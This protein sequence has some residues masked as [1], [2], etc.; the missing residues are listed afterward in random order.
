MFFWSLI[1]FSGYPAV[2]PL[3]EICQF[4]SFMALKHVLPDSAHSTLRTFAASARTL[5]NVAAILVLTAGTHT[6]LAL[7]M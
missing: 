3:N 6:R 7:S 5:A 4:F 2:N 1:L